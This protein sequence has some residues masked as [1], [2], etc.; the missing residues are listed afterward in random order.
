MRRGL[1]V[2]G[3]PAR[4][5]V[6]G[7]LKAYRALVAPVLGERCRFYP[8]CSAYALESVRTHGAV[9]GSMLAMWRLARC[10][11]LSAGG[12]DPVPGRGKWKARSVPDRGPYDSVIQES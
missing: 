12:P 1:W 7:L 8:S 4:V 2:L 11:P 6:V 9:K 3:G 5:L 10:S